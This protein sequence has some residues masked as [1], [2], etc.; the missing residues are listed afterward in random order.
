MATTKKTPLRMC[1]AC[2]E[3]KGKKEMIRI[4]KNKDGDIFLDF[5]GKAAGRGAYLCNQQE[6]V[7]K[8]RKQRLINRA[9]SSEVP[10]EVYDRIEEEFLAQS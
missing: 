7:Q 4:V 1:L 3:M 5:S 9:F 10:M 2:R 6:C 8:L